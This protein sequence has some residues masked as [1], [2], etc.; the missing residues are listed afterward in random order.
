VLGPRG[1]ERT[2]DDDGGIRVLPTPGTPEL[3]LSG[4]IT[5]DWRPG[6]VW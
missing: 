5:C 6:D 3:D 2:E 4:A 1:P